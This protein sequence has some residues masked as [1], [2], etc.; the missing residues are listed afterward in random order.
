MNW[1]RICLAS[2]LDLPYFEEI[3]DENESYIPDE[4]YIVNKLKDRGTIIL[5][6][7]AQ[8]DNGQAYK[9]S[10][11]DVLKITT[12]NKEAK[13]SEW[14]KNHPHPNIAEYKEVWRHDNLYYI[15]MEYLDEVSPSDLYKLFKV[16]DMLENKYECNDPACMAIIIKQYD[17]LMKLPI[18]ND[19]LS[20]LKHIEP[21]RPFDF[22]NIGNVA[23]K[24]GVL[25]FF[26]IT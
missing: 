13:N 3:S 11:G 9:L 17:E 10:N 12:H 4:E 14:L 15:I 24:N 23:R 18:M 8:G 1:F 19:I 16:F 20:Y 25:K 7:I 6:K 21:L 2:I 22:L 26:D 5:H